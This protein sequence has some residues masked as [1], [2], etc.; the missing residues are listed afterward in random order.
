MNTALFFSTFLYLS[1]IGLEIK[2]INSLL[3]LW[4]LYLLLTIPKNALFYAGFFIGIF[5]FYWVSF[6]FIY[7]ELIYLIPLV[8]LGFAL[9]YGI[10]FYL[11]ALFDHII[12]RA[13][14]LFA[15]SYF[16]PLGFNWLQI[17]LLF[18]HSYFGIDKLDLFTLLLSLVLFTYYKYWAFILLIFPLTFAQPK[19]IENALNIDMP[20]LNLPQKDKWKHKNTSAIIDTNLEFIDTAIQ[21]GADVVVLPETSFPLLLNKNQQL[22]ELLQ[23]K[24]NS[25]DIILGSLYENKGEYHNSTYYFSNGN[26]EVG[27]KVVLVPFGEAIPLPEKIRDFI[28]ET[29]YNGAKDYTKANAPTDFDIKGVKFRNAICYETTTPEIFENLN[30]VKYMISISN[31]AWFTPSIEPTLQKL[32]MQYYADLYRVTIYASANGS[33]NQIIVP[34]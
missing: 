23:E 34:R 33:K 29:F 32:L 6:S 14:A 16:A 8:I 20:Q 10:I 5:W 19:P 17:E 12:F 7:Y 26:V 11:T 3:G 30:G 4:A 24:S 21:N 28:N 13:L 31:N 15:L 22:Y 18:V 2:L 25:I 27:H 1:Y 9:G